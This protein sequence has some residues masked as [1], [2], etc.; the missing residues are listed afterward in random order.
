MGILPKSLRVKLQAT[1]GNEEQTVVEGVQVTASAPPVQQQTNQLA[2]EIVKAVAHGQEKFAMEL[3]AAGKSKTE[4]FEALYDDLKK[5]SAEAEAAKPVISAAEVAAE[6]LKELRAG[7]PSM[8]STSEQSGEADVYEQFKAIEDPTASQ[9]FYAAHK[10]EID[11]IANSQKTT[12][13]EG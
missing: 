8:P 7:T 1:K 5:R 10:A 6:V 12:K 11:R 13:K 9:E 3:L 2:A 4:I